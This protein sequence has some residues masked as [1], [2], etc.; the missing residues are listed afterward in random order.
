MSDI[1]K[2]K[3]LRGISIFVILVVILGAVSVAAFI[4]IVKSNTN[5]S[6]AQAI[7][8]ALKHTPGEVLSVRKDL[9]DFILEYDIK[10]KDSNNVIRELTVNSKNGGIVDFID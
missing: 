2:K 5:Y 4:K 3:I 9:D 6:E 1:T 7:E 8:I 10:I